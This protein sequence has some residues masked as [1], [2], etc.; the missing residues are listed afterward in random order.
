V[1]TALISRWHRVEAADTSDSSLLFYISGP[2]AGT[3]GGCTP[4]A[5]RAEANLQR[6]RILRIVTDVSILIGQNW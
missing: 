2:F 5:G 4:V 6:L 3:S 1:D